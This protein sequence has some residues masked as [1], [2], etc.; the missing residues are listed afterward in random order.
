[1]V[2]FP[3]W[4][5]IRVFI[6]STFR[7]FQ[8]ER[9]YLVK[10]VFPRIREKLEPHRIE[11]IDIDLR[12]GVT[13]EQA[14]NDEVLEL[15]LQEIDRCKP[16]KGNSRPYFLGL[17]G[18]RYGWVPRQVDASVLKRYNWIKDYADHSV[19]AL[20]IIHGVLLNPPMHGKSFFYFRDP[21]F[22]DDVPEPMKPKIIA[23]DKE[24]KEKLDDLKEKIRKSGLPVL[25]GY[26][27]HYQGIRIDPRFVREQIETL[28]K[29][30]KKRL[31][32]AIDDAV[33]AA[34]EY[35]KLPDD[36]R[37]LVHN[38]AAVSLKGLKAFGDRVYH[39]LIDAIA[40]QHPDVNKK[41]KE[42][43]E[44]TDRLALEQELHE[45]FAETRLRIVEGRE[46][47]YDEIKSYCDGDVKKPLVVS[48]PSGCGKTT[49][50]AWF[51][52]RHRDSDTYVLPHFIG[53]SGDSVR[54]EGTL[55]RL[56][57][58]LQK[59]FGFPGE[60]PSNPSDLPQTF[61]LFMGL[62]PEDQHAV[63]LIDA[64][65]QLDEQSLSMG[66][67][68]VPDDL[69][70]NVRLIVSCLSDRENRAVYEDLQ[71][72]GFPQ[73]KVGMLS[74]EDC[75][76][77]I[78]KVPSL[79]AKTLDGTQKQLLLENP[80]TTNPLYLQVA[81]EELRGFGSFER[82]NDRIEMFKEAGD[83][84]AL[85]GQ[86]LERLELDFGKAL[87]K[88]TFCLLSASRAGL[89][90]KELEALL[91][92]VANSENLQ[93]LLRQVRSYLLKRGTLVHYYHNAMDRAVLNRYQ[94]G[95]DVPEWHLVLAD[96]FRDKELTDR[97]LDELPWQ[98]AQ[99]K[100]WKALAALLGDME[101][102]AVLWKK[103]KF[104]VLG[105]WQR[106]ELNSES[107]IKKVL[108]KV[109]KYPEKY[110]K[111]DI[112]AL[113]F[114][115]SDTGYLKES[116]RLREYLVNQYR[117]S[118]TSENKNNLQANLGNQ[119]NILYAWGKLEEA[120]ALHKQQEQICRELGNKDG[121]QASLGG[122]AIIFYAW[123]RLEEAMELYKKQEQIC[124][125]LGTK[126]GLQ[127]SLNNQALILADWGRLDEAMELNKQK[128]QICRELG[129]KDGLQASLGN[130]A[131][132]L[133]D[134]GKLEAA[135]EL[136]KQ[137][138]QIC[139]ELSNIDGLQRSLGNQA[140]IL[141]AW[142]KLEEAM[143]LHKQ[144]EQICRELNNLNGL[145]FS[146][147][148]QALLLSQILGK[149]TEALP[150]AEEAVEIFKKVN[151]S[152]VQKAEQDLADIKSKLIE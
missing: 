74:K 124:R 51:Y 8:S 64:L 5:T 146:F 129:N 66:M 88:H 118:D 111:N 30:S 65:D 86:V 112:W 131:L 32:D 55:R 104:E 58:T 94:Q 142:G 138:E 80:A 9:D 59:Q 2:S 70:S 92:D 45:R 11:F 14:E 60:I 26:A 115:F 79:S 134:W 7:D 107:R 68:W 28:A 29:K 91:K 35:E 130:Q 90:E 96:Y 97:K 15:C 83:V 139:R 113:S 3:K 67:H 106:V 18:E 147:A 77:I 133:A 6:S 102:F 33:V 105:Y 145:A 141:K 120:M 93:P 63:I 47:S 20:E 23:E 135:M 12:W 16:E 22:I 48:G 89:A 100:D 21:A 103:N 125:E 117:I 132:I 119:A 19:T 85:F 101:F 1:M 71:K 76:N 43:T 136:H 140:V 42:E 53:A 52:Q 149:H 87:V 61:R 123:G 116:F 36:A 69:P 24:S 56:C 148:N 73:V 152:M 126:D 37:D 128:E 78:T 81:L 122:Q 34:D 54:L 17:L 150:L 38:N 75:E 144:E 13:Q 49:L 108:R 143:E 99:A 121:L 62:V 4:K 27:C 98:Y 25:D 137:Q 50:L 41:A 31:T 82:L 46:K 110:N 57:E 44:E 114:L 151:P 84:T 39:D 127:A 109:V 95:K 10:H 72:R 40:L